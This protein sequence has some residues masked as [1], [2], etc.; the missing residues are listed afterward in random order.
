MVLSFFFRFTF[1]RYFNTVRIEITGVDREIL[2]SM[3]GLK[4]KKAP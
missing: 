3:E 2:G 4:I 1:N